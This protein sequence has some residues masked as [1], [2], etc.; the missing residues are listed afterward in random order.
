M[1]TQ[2]GS[3]GQI[4]GAM[5]SGRGSSMGVRMTKQLNE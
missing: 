2:K 1:C 3:A 4:L 5:Y